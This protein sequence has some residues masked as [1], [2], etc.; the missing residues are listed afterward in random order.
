[1]PYS[2]CGMIFLWPK[3][4]RNCSSKRNVII[5][6]G[7]SRTNA[8]TKPLKK[9]SGPWRAVIFITSISPLNSPGLAFI[10]RVF[11][12]SR[13]CVNVVAIAPAINDEMKC[14][15]GLSSKYGVVSNIPLTLRKSKILSVFIRVI[16]WLHAKSQLKI[17]FNYLNLKLYHQI[18]IDSRICSSGVRDYITFWPI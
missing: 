11:S 9:P 18:C 3:F 14:K 13:G 15:L 12:T 16:K 1:M 8:G 5:V 7:P 10:T 6:C 4:K 17:F 2:G